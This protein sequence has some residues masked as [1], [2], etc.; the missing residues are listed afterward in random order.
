[1]NVYTKVGCPACKMTERWLTEHGFGYE[2]LNTTERT[3]L[4]NDLKLQGY[5]G[6]PVVVTANNSWQGFRPDY[7]SKYLK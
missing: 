4:L 5:S 2:E 1:M 7:L 6:L 3:E